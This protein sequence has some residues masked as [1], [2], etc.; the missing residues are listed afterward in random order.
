MSPAACQP[1]DWPNT[2]TRLSFVGLPPAIF[3]V[4]ECGPLRS[5]SEKYAGLLREAGVPIEYKQCSG[6]NHGFI[7]NLDLTPSSP[8]ALDYAAGRIV[9]ANGTP[10]SARKGGGGGGCSSD[11]GGQPTNP[12]TL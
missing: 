3:V 9:V 11:A 6:M 1:G 12:A 2:A 7:G 10:P 5:D 8:A 4:A